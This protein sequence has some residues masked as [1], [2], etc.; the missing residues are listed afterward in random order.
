[1]EKVASDLHQS[2][3]TYNP[4]QGQMVPTITEAEA[5]VEVAQAQSALLNGVDVGW[6]LHILIGPNKQIAVGAV[7]E[8][9]E[10]KV[11]LK[12]HKKPFSLS[13]VCTVQLPD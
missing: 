8:V 6:M 7:K 12:G 9:G 3:H 4:F 5:R 10:T 11:W 2:R 1:L 13:E